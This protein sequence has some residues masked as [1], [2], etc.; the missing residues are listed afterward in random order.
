MKLQ[1]FNGGLS[2]RLRPHMINTNE[3]EVYTNI[4]NEVGTLAPVKSKVESKLEVEQ[5]NYLYIAFKEWLTHVIPR[6]YV[7]YQK[8]LYWSDG[9][10]KP[11][12]YDGTNQYN[13]GINAPIISPTVVQGSDVQ[14]VES[15]DMTPGFSGDLPSTSH[16][17]ILVNDNG[18][19]FSAPLKLD[20][21]LS[22]LNT[23][24]DWEDEDYGDWYDYQ[25]EWWNRPWFNYSVTA[26]RNVVI[27]NIIGLTFG[28]NGV[29]VY[30]QYGTQYY[31]VGSLANAAAVLDDSVYDISANAV[32]D[33]AAISPLLGTLQY[34]YTFYNSADG[35]ESVQ[36]P[37]SPEQ[38]VNE[39]V[40][41]SDMEVSLD[42]QVDKKRIYRIGGNLASYGLVAEVDNADT[43]YVDNTKDTLII[44]TILTS[45]DHVA[46]PDGMKH[47]TEAYAMMFGSEDNKLRFSKIGEPNY[48]PEA[49]YLL[50]NDTITGIA[51][52]ANGVIVF[53]KLRSYIVTGTGPSSLSQH[54]L[55]GDQGCISEESIQLISDSAVWVSTDGVCVSTGSKVDVVTKMKLGKLAVSPVDSA[56]HDEVYYVLEDDRTMLAVDFRYDLVMKTLKVE[57][58]SLTVADDRLF[59]HYAGT[60]FALFE[61][62]DNESFEYH[63]PKFIEG[64]A[65]EEKTYKKVYIYSKGDIIITILID[66]KEVM[67]KELSTEGS[68]QLQVP[69]SLQRG[70]R[71]QF[72]VSGTGEVTEIEYV[73]GNRQN[74]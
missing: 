29:K 40:T 70:H 12:K 8:K 44:G 39:Q 54:V 7:E 24:I 11:Q 69:Q 38:Q 52:V 25:S 31:L 72:V 53:T 17:Y 47:L 22:S 9:E 27:Q 60:M 32:F 37:A 59:G 35:T 33:T 21:N 65:T 45:Q 43:T 30:R 2:T 50:F 41:L 67:T 49:F 18:T 14:A 66:D 46:A 26:T 16:K 34:V 36:S 64:K 61:S 20:V 56:I 19:Y 28:V 62:D 68:H 4:D 63:S 55:S 73:V 48:W 74:D 51:P 23:V 71:I 42:P 5:Y 3:A 15:V 13:L 58:D 6:S 57:V 10:N 1:Q